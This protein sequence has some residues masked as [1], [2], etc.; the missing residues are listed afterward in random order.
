[1]PLEARCFSRQRR[2]RRASRRGQRV[3]QPQIS[4]STTCDGINRKTQSKAAPGQSGH[5]TMAENISPKAMTAQENTARRCYKSQEHLVHSIPPNSTPRLSPPPADTTT[6]G[7]SRA[8]GVIPKLPSSSTPHPSRNAPGH[9]SHL[10]PL[11]TATPGPNPSEF[12]VLTHFYLDLL[13]S[14]TVPSLQCIK[15]FQAHLLLLLLS[16]RSLSR[17]IGGLKS[18]YVTSAGTGF[19]V[20]TQSY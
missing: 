12:T 5:P 14:L 10:S 3:V 8:P 15:L 4:P 2:R 1:M 6:T 18:P 13:M 16:T 11:W 20:G 9:S 19:R 7:K 17:A